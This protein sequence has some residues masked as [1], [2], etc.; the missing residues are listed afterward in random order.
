MKAKRFLIKNAGLAM[1]AGYE[2]LGKAAAKG[3]ASVFFELRSVG[4]GPQNVDSV[5]ASDYR[6]VITN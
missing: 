3:G 5:T 4:N 1:I 2:G 6:S